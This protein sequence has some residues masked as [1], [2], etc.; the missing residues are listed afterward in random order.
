MNLIK[1]QAKTALNRINNKYLPQKWDLNI[2]RGCAHKCV[3]CYA[4]YSHQFMENNDFF[5]DLYVKENIVKLLEEKLSSKRWKRD[6]INFGGVTDSYQAAESQLKLMPQILKLFIR[7]RTPLMISTK[8]DLILR[9][10]DLFEELSKVA[11]VSVAFTVTTLD[12]NIRKKIEPASSP[13]VERLKALSEFKKRR[14]SVGLHAMPLLPFLTDS[15]KNIDQLFEAA[16]EVPVDYVIAGLLNLKGATKNYYFDFLKKEYPELVEKY[17]ELYD[18]AFLKKEYR[19]QVYKRI[20]K[21]KEK[22]NLSDD[23]S[24]G[25]PKKDLAE[26]LSLI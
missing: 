23:Y 26:Q 13:S 24:K 21:L 2:Y 3:Y 6:L 19:Y 16:S 10:I 7:Y 12:E 20:K 15:E 8:S 14:I 17:L 5:N 11:S 9:D 25:L 22:H 18:G 1:I 4:L